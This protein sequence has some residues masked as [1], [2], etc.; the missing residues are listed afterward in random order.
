MLDVKLII[1]LS[2]CYILYNLNSKNILIT[3]PNEIRQESLALG[4]P[5]LA[6][7]QTFSL[8]HRP[9]DVK[10]PQFAEIL[11]TLSTEQCKEI[12]ED[13]WSQEK[14]KMD[15]DSFANLIDRNAPQ[16]EAFKKF[17]NENTISFLGGGNA[18]NYK[19]T[20]KKGLPPYI[21]RVDPRFGNPSSF[22]LNLFFRAYD[23][24]LL[25]LHPQSC[26]RSR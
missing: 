12:T 16:Y 25:V 3:L 10:I 14:E 1:V 17:I 20:P 24:Q 7:L 9:L 18:K 15:M 8:E 19:V 6:K 5:S 26:L 21:I 13:L 23:T 11:A 2:N 4:I 22:Y